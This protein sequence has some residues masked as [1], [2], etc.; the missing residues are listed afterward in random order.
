MRALIFEGP[1]SVGFTDRRTE[2]DLL[3]GSDALVRVS[4]AGLC[5]SDLHP[6]LGREPLASGTIPGH[7]AVGVIAAL[8]PAVAGLEVGQRV[9]VP[10]TT[11]CG[12]CRRCTDGLTARCE[13][14]ELFGWRDP[15]SADGGLDG[16]QAEIVRVPLAASTLVA[17]D[18][19]ADAVALLLADNMPT[20]YAALERAKVSDSLTVVGLGSVGLCAV[21]LALRRGVGRVVA[22][23]PDPRRSAVAQSIGAIVAEPGAHEPTTAVIES[24]GSADAQRT[25][26]GAAAPGSVVSVIS[27]QTSQHMPFTP[28]EA[29]DR[30][31]TVSWGRA[32]VRSVLDREWEFLAAAAAE[33]ADVVVDRQGV[34]M[35][36]G[37]G[38]Y[39]AFADREFVKAAFDPSR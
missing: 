23:D 4:A 31:L 10:F 1:G 17:A 39:R 6:Y 14:G 28:I 5:G 33:M 13:L 24:A 19:V 26:I 2:P 11:S 38:A 25:A 34:P 8:G 22:I 7:E 32:S 21:S 3:S 9:I 15:D 29:Y 36:E 12:T 35:S 16:C 37:P 30:N 20:A 18:G 27:V